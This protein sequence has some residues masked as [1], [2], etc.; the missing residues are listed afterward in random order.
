MNY[1]GQSLLGHATRLEKAR[2]I[3]AGTKLRDTQLH[4]PGPCLPVALAVAVALGKPK[5]VLLAIARAGLRTDL[6]LHKLLGG[7]PDHLAKQIGVGALLNK[8][9]QVHHLVGHRWSFHQVGLRQTDPTGK[10][11]M[12]TATLLHHSLGHHH[13]PHE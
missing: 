4:G 10:T 8:R 2:E 13:S 11:L 7:K 12:A 9:A 5:G 3:G 6:K 1:G